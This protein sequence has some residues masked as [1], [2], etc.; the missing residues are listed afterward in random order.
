[1]RIKVGMDLDDLAGAVCC[2]DDIECLREIFN[3]DDLESVLENVLDGLD[4]EDVEQR[5][6]NNIF[7]ILS[8]LVPAD[9]P[10]TK[11]QTSTLS[12]TFYPDVTM[13]SLREHGIPIEGP[14]RDE[15]GEYELVPADD[16][17]QM[18]LFDETGLPPP[19]KKRY[20]TTEE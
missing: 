15:H 13:E 7:K 9:R 1:M 3:D 11:E 12:D 19:M 5:I 4:V 14:L 6:K 8:G 2:A 17:R 16:P 20:I 10:L 18:T